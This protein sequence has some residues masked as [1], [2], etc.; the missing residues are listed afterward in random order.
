MIN[1]GCF[2]N[3]NPGQPLTVAAGANSQSN[4]SLIVPLGQTQQNYQQNY[5][6]YSQIQST[7]QLVQVQPQQQYSP[8]QVVTT[9]LSYPVDGS[10]LD[11]NSYLPQTSTVQSG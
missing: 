5:Q 11:S 7:P 2:G 6:Q 1:N 3:Y 8:S 4:Q 9:T 10:S